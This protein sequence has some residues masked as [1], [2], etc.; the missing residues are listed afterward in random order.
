MNHRKILSFDIGIRNLGVA[1]VE[2]DFSA[3]SGNSSHPWSGLHISQLELIDIIGEMTDGKNSSIKPRANAKVKNAKTVNIHDLCSTIVK[4][5]HA[6]IRWTDNI[7]DIRVEQQPIQ[8]GKFGGGGGSV[9]MKIIQHC[10]LTFFETYY[11]LNPHLTKPSIQPASPSNKL[12]CIINVDNFSIKPLTATEKNTD[13][14]T[15]KNQTEENF[16]KCIEWCSISK[17]L[18]TTYLDSGKKNDLSDCVL[19]A[20]FELQ[21]FGAKLQKPK[22]VK[23]IKSIE[24]KPKKR[25]VN[26][27]HLT[28]IQFANQM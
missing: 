5:L 19:Q 22:R 17:E 8:Q 23:S 10:I 4:S 25:K 20:V 13:Y 16:T 7:T 12:K 6:R 15:R 2:Y 14:K 18:K 28:V 27:D 11:T 26:I 1:V 21:T 3:L 24:S 9:R